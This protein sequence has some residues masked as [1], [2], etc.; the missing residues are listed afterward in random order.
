M[1]L[2]REVRGQDGGPEHENHQPERSRTTARRYPVWSA[3]GLAI[4]GIAAI[5]AVALWPHGHRAATPAGST[6]ATSIQTPT[7]EPSKVSVSPRTSPSAIAGTATAQNL[8]IPDN[9]KADLLTAFV[10]TK[11][12]QPSEITGPVS[13]SVFYG[14]LPATDTYWA[15]ADFALSPTAAEQTKVDFQDGGDLGI[16]HHR[17]G[18]NW[19]VTVGNYP[20]PC[21]GDLPEGMRS[22][23]GLSINP[24]CVI[25]SASA[26]DRGHTDNVITLPDGTYFGEVKTLQYDVDGT[27]SMLFDPYTWADGGNPVDTRPGTWDLLD[28]DARTATRYGD[29]TS[30][31]VSDGVFDRAFAQLVASSMP[32]FAGNLNDGYIVTLKSN[33]ITSMTQVGPTDPMPSSHPSYTEPTG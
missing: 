5:V 23:W 15:V 4:A 27:A 31:T 30:G 26:P 1:N 25:I 9:V 21:P 17:P 29:G 10:A 22:V 13:G 24:G 33:K 3:A 18:Q 8:R 6:P 16:F 2:Q 7:S 28:A 20:W 19:Q 12:A 32:E 14:Y 11:K